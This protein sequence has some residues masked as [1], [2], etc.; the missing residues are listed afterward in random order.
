MARGQGSGQHWFGPDLVVLSE[1]T[2]DVDDHRF[3]DRE[4]VALVGTDRLGV[5]LVDVEYQRRPF[6]P[7]RGGFDVRDQEAPNAAAAIVLMHVE[8]VGLELPG[9]IGPI[10]GGE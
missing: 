2:A 10:V 9:M 5:A 6:L 1:A 3:A 4:R 7:D 8:L